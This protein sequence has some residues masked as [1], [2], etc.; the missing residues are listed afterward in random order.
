MTNLPKKRVDATEPVSEVFQ[1]PELIVV[2]FNYSSK[3]ILPLNQG[4][5]LMALLS[6]AWEYEEGYGS[7]SSP[8]VLQPFNRDMKVAYMTKQRFNEMRMEMVLEKD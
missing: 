1:A 6:Q 7:N 4:L 3:V 8:K 5:D 2:E